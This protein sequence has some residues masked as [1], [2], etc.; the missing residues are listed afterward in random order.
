M[1]F[2]YQHRKWVTLFAIY[3]PD[4]KDMGEPVVAA[5]SPLFNSYLLSPVKA[6]SGARCRQVTVVFGLHCFTRWRA[7]RLHL[8]TSTS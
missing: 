3:Q 2:A 7:C 5:G 1:Y 4:W 8:A 6:R